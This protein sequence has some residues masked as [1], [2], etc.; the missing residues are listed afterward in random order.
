MINP[1]TDPVVL[2]AEIEQACQTPSG[3]S[4]LAALLADLALLGH[5][6]TEEKRTALR[7]NSPLHTQ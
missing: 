4:A 7:Y 6:C 3:R 1:A 2:L 5:R